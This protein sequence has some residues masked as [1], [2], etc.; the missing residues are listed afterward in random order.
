MLILFRSR[1]LAVLAMLFLLATATRALADGLIIIKDPPRPIPGHFTFAPLEVGYHHV[2]TTIDDQLATTKID[3]EII[4]SNNV[5]LEG[6]YIFPVPEGVTIN[7]FKMDIDGKMVDAEL[8]PADKARGI[9]EDVVRKM[10][11]PALLEYAGRAVFRVRIFPIEPN[12]KKRIQISYT[13]LLRQDNNLLHYQ[14]TLNTEK[15][16]AKPIKDVSLKISIKSNDPLTTIYSPSNDI[17][18]IHHG[19]KEATVG[20]EAKDV[21]PDR[22]FHLY[23][24]KK[25]FSVGMSLLTYK[26]DADKDGYFVLMAAPTLSPTAKAIPKDVVFVMDTSGSMAGDKITQAKKALRYCVDTLNPQDHFE[27]V[28]FSTEA[29]PLFKTLKDASDDNRKTADAFIDTLRA[30][31]GTAIDEALKAA[32]DLK[33]ADDTGRVFMVVFVTDGQPTVGEQDTDKILAGVRS[34]KAAANVRVFS[35][36]VGT[37][38]NTR[39]LDELAA[40]TRGFSQYVLPNENIEVAVSNFFGKVQ[41]PVLAGLK[42]DTGAV[43]VTKLTPREMPDLFKGDQLVLFGTYA[44]AGKTAVVLSGTADGKQQKFAQ[45]VSFDDKTDNKN[46]W[47]G[48][49]WAVRRVGYL[50]D[51]IRHDGESKELK[52]EVVTLARRWGIVTPYTAM[53]IIE[54]EKKS[55]VAMNRQSLSDLAADAPAME[56]A[57]AG[58][59]SLAQ[60]TGGQAVGNAINMNSYKD[61]QS[62]ESFDKAANQTNTR[63]RYG[64]QDYAALDHGQGGF[65]GGAGGGVRRRPRRWWWCWR[66]LWRWPMAERR[67]HAAVGNPTSNP[68]WLRE[69]HTR[70]TNPN[71]SRRPVHRLPRRHQLRPAE[72]RHQQPVLLPQR[73]PVD[74]FHRANRQVRQNGADCLQLRRLL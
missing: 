41:D 33:P 56:Q 60:T 31:G 22:D 13:E 11:D 32:L 58:S 54:D 35:F 70:P 46:E 37:D 1:I 34:N 29:E 48:K 73:Q 14:Y 68:T 69:H 62:M 19:D 51:Q 67:R 61:A 44:K 66:R 4:N 52:D 42:L 9:Y 30:S 8:L 64:N 17:E 16:S 38:V 21:R 57:R 55:G 40:Q 49:L 3:Q 15:Y 47:I 71:R 45:D 39:L 65:G 10:K 7:N 20:Y 63:N 53:L 27:I 23:I 18:V 59:G 25:A 6:D 72:P 50:L 43:N 2:E 12:S 36:G 74:R 24:G 26:P 5:R 28:R